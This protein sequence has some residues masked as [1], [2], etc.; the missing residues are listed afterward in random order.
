MRSRE[1]E[2]ETSESGGEA[3]ANRSGFPFLL[4]RSVLA[5][6]GRRFTFTALPTLN[7]ARILVAIVVGVGIRSL[8]IW[9]VYTS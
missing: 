8:A 7:L 9:L 5:Q 6:G 1:D 2:R 4:F 3:L